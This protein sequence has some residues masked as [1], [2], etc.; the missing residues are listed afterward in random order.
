MDRIAIVAA[1]LAACS[2][3]GAPRAAGAQR[4]APIESGRQL[5]THP[6][7][8]ADVVER[9]LRDDPNLHLGEQLADGALGAAISSHALYDMTV[10]TSVAHSRQNGLQLGAP[11]QP[12]S[13]SPIRTALSSTVISSVSAQKRLPWGG[14]TIAP[15][16]SISG[17]GTPGI[18]AQS[19][20]TTALGVTVPLGR[21]RG[22]ALAS[23]SQAAAYA[24]A[25]ATVADLR[26]AASASALQAVYSYWAF[27]AAQQ[28]LAVLNATEERARRNLSQARDLVAADERPA[29]DLVQ[30]RGSVASRIASRVSAEQSLLDAW[31]TLAARFGAGDVD[32]TEI[33]RGG[34]DFPELPDSASLRSAPSASET[35]ALIDAALGQ[36]SDVAA[37]TTRVRESEYV[38]RAAN[39]LMRP[40]VDVVAQIGYSG[41]DQG[42][43]LN[44]YLSPLYRNWSPLNATIQFVY[45]FSAVN[46][47]ASGRYRQAT[48][49]LDAQRISRGV[50]ERS[51][52][53]GVVVA[54]SDVR[55][56]IASA[57]ASRTS[58]LA[59][60]QSVEN[61]LHM[62]R[63]GSATVIDVVLSEEGLTSALLAEIAGRQSYAG[64]LARLQFELGTLV[65]G[66]R[67]AFVG[68]IA[69]LTR[70]P[71]IIATP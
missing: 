15:Q 16:F 31:R 6:L 8:L 14:L 24:E 63:L 11:P 29:A 39:H 2:V 17:A 66:D 62:F 60:Q 25:D 44:P 46:S 32:I 19:R 3:I 21:D 51:I 50:L 23:S 48:A 27:I 36:R 28:R 30:L 58:T 49:N 33:P 22:G 1:G 69:A 41:L 26:Q 64:A 56:T 42:S 59:A 5:A 20:A 47:D 68:N 7:T 45:E 70:A 35:R 38:V 13:P 40:V 55:H 71:A 18:V 43:G 52:T 67:Q 54:L 65:T 53:T 12:G 37:T 57:Q 34:S 9:A 61:E 4:R 10:Q